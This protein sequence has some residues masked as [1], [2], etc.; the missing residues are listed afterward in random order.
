MDTFL[1]YTRRIGLIIGIIIL[2]SSSYGMT[3][4]HKVYVNNNFVGYTQDKS[5]VKK[6]YKNILEGINLKFS[7][8]DKRINTLNFEF[9]SDEGD[10]T[11]S[12]KLRENIVNVLDIEVAVYAMNIDDV[13]IGYVNSFNAGD[14]ALNILKTEG[15]L[16]SEIDANDIVNL[17]I[18]GDI[19]YSK[20]KV[21]IS[22]VDSPDDIIK[23]I[24]NINQKGGNNIG[25]VEILEIKTDVVDIKQD[26]KEITTDR[27]CL[28]E[29]VKHEGEKGIKEVKRRNSYV[30]GNLV[31]ST[32][33]EEKILK[34]AKEDIIYKGIQNPVGNNVEFLVYPGANRYITSPYGK[35]W[36]NEHHSGID[37]GGKTGDTIKASYEGVVKYAGWLGGY[38]NAV[39]ISHG[40]GVET[41]YAHASKLTCSTGQ[42]VSK[43]DKI[44]E[45]G[46]TG[47]STG[48]HIHFEL[49]NNGRAINPMT[50]MKK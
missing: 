3:N 14:E 43:G 2:F 21:K 40:S 4:L 17:A 10:V 32:V 20:K 28:G 30:E 45:I 42:R 49:R 44:A 1:K 25:S 12:E 36:G 24:N 26:A 16:K 35:R 29:V 48:P 7:E 6:I 33:L 37:L 23:N 19:S 27:L 41:L 31:D 22:D 8:V 38:G 13:N 5:E 15:N 34:E 9:S 18:Q 39:I 11:S 46:S 47:R 50:Y